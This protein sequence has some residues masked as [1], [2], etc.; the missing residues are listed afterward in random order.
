[1]E[2]NTIV[3]RNLLPNNRVLK[4]NCKSNKKDYSLGSVKFKGLPHRINIREACIE[5][6]TW[7]CLL[8]QGGFASIFRA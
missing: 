4:V 6:T 2:E 3:F 7:T 1:C 8:Q 5:R